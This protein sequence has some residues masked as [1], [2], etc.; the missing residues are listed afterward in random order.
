MVYVVQNPIEPVNL[1]HAVTH[2]SLTFIFAAGEKIEQMPGQSL[3]KARKAL[4]D[5]NSEEDFMLFINSKSSNPHALT[6][7][8]MALGEL[9]LPFVNWLHWNR[10]KDSAGNVV[11]G[12]GYYTPVRYDLRARRS[13]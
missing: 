13:A 11:P 10:G 2:G 9:N 6:V 4:R 8:S 3:L 1:T 12:N 7:C 5:F